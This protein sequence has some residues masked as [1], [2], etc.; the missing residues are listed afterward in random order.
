M[1]DLQ[2]SYN[3]FTKRQGKRRDR[4]TSSGDQSDMFYWS[5]TKAMPYVL[6]VPE[7]ATILLF[8]TL[9]VLYWHVLGLI[10]FCSLDRSCKTCFDTN[11]FGVLSGFEAKQTW[12]RHQIET[13][14][15]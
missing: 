12:R 14:S 10:K 2:M 11:R 4:G 13:F 7:G 9:Q 6:E 3:D 5:I 8:D 15:T 1:I